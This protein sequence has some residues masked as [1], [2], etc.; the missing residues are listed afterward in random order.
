[1]AIEVSLI[2]PIYNGEQYIMNILLDL[3]KQTFNDVEFLLIDDGSSDNSVS[4]IQKFITE[5]KD[6]RFKLIIKKNGGVS[7]ARN[8]GLDSANGNYIMFADSDDRLDEKFVEAYYCSITA[9]NSEMEFFSAI[10]V[11]DAE[12]LEEIGRIDYTPVAT[13]DS[14][15]VRKMIT[16]FSDLQAWGYPFSVISEKKLWK[17]VRFDPA[18][19]FQ[20]DVQAFFKI[21]LGNP[22]IKISLNAKAY[23]YYVQ[24]KN[25]ALHTMKPGD[26]WQF[27]GVDTEI[28]KNISEHKSLN[29]LVPTVKSLL[30]S[31]LINVMAVSLIFKDEVSYSKSRKLFLREFKKTNFSKNMKLRRIIQYILVKLNCKVILTKVYGRIYKVN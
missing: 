4:V 6:K 27:V 26:H 20:E 31:S 3:R 15:S 2:I 14:I 1:M 22:D 30:I 17:N 13:S 21:W 19:K 16:L 18:V 8:T 5:Q 12:K 9:H 29:D 7:S 10:K 24:R 25:S 23:Y 11:D 28:I